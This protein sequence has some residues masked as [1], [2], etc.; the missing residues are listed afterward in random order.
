MF[1]GNAEKMSKYPLINSK[2]VEALAPDEWTKNPTEG[3]V[4]CFKST[5]SSKN[6]SKSQHVIERINV[7]LSI[8]KI[9]I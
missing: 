1:T 7:K 6:E 4:S 2:V 8:S 9:L 5:W 3:S